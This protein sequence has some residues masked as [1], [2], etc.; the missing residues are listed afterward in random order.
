LSRALRYYYDKNIIKKVIGQKFVYRFV[1][2]NKQAGGIAECAGAPGNPEL[3]KYAMTKAGL[4]VNNGNGNAN[5]IAQPSRG[6]M[7][8]ARFGRKQPN[9]LAFCPF[10]NTTPSLF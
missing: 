10:K 6:Q 9:G 8:A 2:D 1:M 7:E 5:G 3:V 4:N